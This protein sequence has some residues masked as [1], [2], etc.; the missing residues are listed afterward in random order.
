ML[1]FLPFSGIWIWYR[2]HKRGLPSIAGVVWASAIFFAC[3]TPWLVRN[4]RTFGHF[5]FIRDDFGLQ[6]RLGNGPYADGILMAYLQPNMNSLEFEKFRSMGERAYAED[7]KRQAFA[8]IRDHPQRF[9]SI[10]FKR[11]IYYWAGVPRATSSLRIFDFG[12]FDFR[13]SLF[14]ASSVLALWG[15]GLALRKKK[16]RASLFLWL[17]LSYPTVYYFVFPHAR[18]RHPIEPELLI[19]TVYLFSELRKR[20]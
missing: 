16:P 2:R 17:V 4:Y 14:L 13:N 10:S 15:L 8:W 6:F 3:L 1:S 5:V 19:V 20:A 9:I 12:P 7:C 18:Y 11:F